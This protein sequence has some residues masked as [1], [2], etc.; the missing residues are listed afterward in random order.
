MFA[1]PCRTEDCKLWQTPWI[2]VTES[3]PTES[4]GS[5]LV[6]HTDVPP[7]NFM[8]PFVNAKHDRR[9]EFGH[10]SEHTNRWYGTMGEFIEDIIG[11]MPLPSPP[12]W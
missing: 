3:L 4:D 5:V 12:K 1:N 7:Y 2:S 9:V 6:C 8:E 11:W 10:Y